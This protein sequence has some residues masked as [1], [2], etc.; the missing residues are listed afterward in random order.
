MGSSLGSAQ[1][2][3]EFLVSLNDG[4]VYP[5]FQQL[6]HALL[7]PMRLRGECG[8]LAG[9]RHRTKRKGTIGCLQLVGQMKIFAT[10]GAKAMSTAQFWW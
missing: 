8:S 4:S 10:G 2:T 5:K 7:P 3:L 6:T 1:V 9:Q